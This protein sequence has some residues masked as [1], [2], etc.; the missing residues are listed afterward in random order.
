MFERILKTTEFSFFFF[1]S[2]GSGMDPVTD[3]YEH[4]NEPSGSLN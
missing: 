3:I 4:G 1:F 2:T